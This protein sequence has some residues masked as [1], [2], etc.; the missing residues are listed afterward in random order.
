MSESKI[1]ISMKSTAYKEIH[2]CY[3]KIVFST[4]QYFSSL[5]M[6]VNHCNAGYK[7]RPKSYV[8]SELL[9]VYPPHSPD[10]SYKKSR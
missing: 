5:L 7:L 9:K 8:L 10:F 4:H 1:I 6:T 2:S 3:R